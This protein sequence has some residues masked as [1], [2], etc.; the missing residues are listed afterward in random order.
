[1][2]RPTEARTQDAV[3]VQQCSLTGM[4]ER[5]PLRWPTPPNTPPSP[6]SRYRSSYQYLGWAE[7]E[8]RADWHN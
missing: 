8:N 4:Q 1:M 7:L 2:A 6:K 3:F 5:L